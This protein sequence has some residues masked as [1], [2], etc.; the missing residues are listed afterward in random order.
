MLSRWLHTGIRAAESALSDGRID[1]AFDRLASP[2]LR[3]QRRAQE[4]L[5]DL[6]RQLLARARLHAQ[7]GRYRDVLSDLDKLA[8]I[9]RVGSDALAL[10]KRVEEEHGKR[11]DRHAAE[12]DAFKR[13]SAQLDAGRL[14]S[15]RLSIEQLEDP[16]RRE[17]LREQLDVRLQRSEQMLAQASTSLA[18]GDVLAACRFWEDATQRHGRTDSSDRMAI[19]LGAALH[20]QI[21]GWI[22]SGQLD[23]PAVAASFIRSLA[24]LSPA[25]EEQQRMI[26][27]VNVAARQ[28]SSGDFH[29]LRDSLLR[30]S[31]SRSDAAWARDLSKQVDQL[32]TARAALL[33]SPLGLLTAGEPLHKSPEILIAAPREIRHDVAPREAS[34][35]IVA[36]AVQPARNATSMLLLVDGTGSALIVRRDLVRIGRG[37]SSQKMDVPM[38]A[39]IQSHHADIVQSGDDY[40]IVAHGPVRVNQK[41]VT[42]VLL[43]DGDRILLGATT[44]LV[45]SRPSVKSETAVLRLADRNRLPQDVS[46]VVLLRDT[47]LIGPQESC[48]VRTREGED[49]VLLFERDGQL[50]ARRHS[51]N[52]REKSAAFEL[53]PSMPVEI[54][55][56]R[57]TVKKYDSRDIA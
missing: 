34:P 39:D 10:R 49:R 57:L 3:R 38:P 18:A 7:A 14:E 43:R 32:T 47:C 29:G 55:E 13:A 26:D 4:L 1:E 35:P 41:P 23:R 17:Q 12:S 27:L 19:E 8:A 56:L 21:D 24:P 42:K 11:I 50:L 33:A 30:I 5:D 28:L 31:A 16:Q 54:G 40:F 22:A 15:G 51:S 44:K 36:A 45:F 46:V 2:D 53:L 20:R 48:H 52:L 25:L 37:G 9:D 6:A